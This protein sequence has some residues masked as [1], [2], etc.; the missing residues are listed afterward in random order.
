MIS[1]IGSISTGGASIMISPIGSIKTPSEG[2]PTWIGVVISLLQPPNIKTE[3][4]INKFI[5]LMV[6]P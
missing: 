4:I 1:P 5:V 6:S 2:S 3:M